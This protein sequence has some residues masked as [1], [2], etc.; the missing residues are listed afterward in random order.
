MI[1]RYSK[2]DNAVVFGINKITHS[3][4]FKMTMNETGKFDGHYFF[5]CRNL[6]GNLAL[7]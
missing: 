6:K 7:S 5:Y 3:Y 1:T 2:K 4:T